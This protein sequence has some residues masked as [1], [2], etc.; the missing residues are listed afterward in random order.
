MPRHVRGLLNYFKYVLCYLLTPEI[1]SQCYRGLLLQ[2]LLEVCNV[3]IEPTSIGDDSLTIENVRVYSQVWPPSAKL[4]HFRDNGFECEAAVKLQRL[5]SNQTQAEG[6]NARRVFF[7]VVIQERMLFWA[8]FL[9]LSKVA[10][11]VLV[12]VRHSE[13]HLGFLLLVS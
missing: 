6:Q 10:R 12:E 3:V 11:G 5:F 8:S 4:D 7:N 9:S 2:A 1:Q 13:I